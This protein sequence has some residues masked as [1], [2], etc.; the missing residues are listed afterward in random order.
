MSSPMLAEVLA[1]DSLTE[2]SAMCAFL[3]VACSLVWPKS[4]PIIDRLPY[5][6]ALDGDSRS[7]FVPTSFHK[8]H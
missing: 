6:S 5:A 8:F 3:A 2:A 4:C 7:R 1:A